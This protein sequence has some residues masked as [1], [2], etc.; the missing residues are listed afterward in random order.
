MLEG[1]R[2]SLRGLESRY[3]AI[4]T[5]CTRT[6]RQTNKQMDRQTL[7]LVPKVASM[8]ENTIL[9]VLM[10]MSALL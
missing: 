3:G 8:T 7:L 10:S 9:T 4:E 6:D 1:A 2:E 5:T